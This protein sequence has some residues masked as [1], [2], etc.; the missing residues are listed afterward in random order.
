MQPCWALAVTQP[1]SEVTVSALLTRQERTNHVF[2]ERFKAVQ[3][4]R[5]VTVERVLFPRY[6]F[7]W[8]RD[9]Q[10]WRAVL[11][12]RGVIDYVRIGAA[13]ARMMPDAMMEVFSRFGEDDILIGGEMPKSKFTCGDRVR[14]IG[15]ALHATR[16]G[17]ECSYYYPVAGGK[18]K[19]LMP[20]LGQLIPTEV[21]ERDLELIEAPARVTKSKRP[22]RKAA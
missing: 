15:S 17:C 11:E 5:V 18:A 9:E 2:R 20:W 8:Q 3:R 1:R 14:Y 13:P 21:L 12:T 22:R 10:D 6:V 4:H 19:V 16:Y 7:V